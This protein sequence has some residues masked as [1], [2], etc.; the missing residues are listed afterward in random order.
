MISDW[1]QNCYEARE[2]EDLE[3][4]KELIWAS[5][6]LFDAVL[7]DPDSAWQL[8]LDIIKKDSSEMILSDVGAGPLEDLLSYHA[9]RF[10]DRVEAEARTN[11]AFRTA[12]SG[13]WQSDIPGAIW[14]RIGAAV[15]GPRL[16]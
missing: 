9:E 6:E 1:I 15:G 16:Q 2:N 8:I 14:A 11:Q 12:L 4:S 10:I 7:H 13:V 3:P 5:S